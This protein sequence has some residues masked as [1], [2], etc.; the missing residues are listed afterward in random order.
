MKQNNI[1][2]KN[3][4]KFSWNEYFPQEK[5]IPT[6]ESFYQCLVFDANNKTLEPKTGNAYFYNCLFQNMKSSASGG[7]I[8]YQK[9]G[10]CILIERCSFLNCSSSSYSGAVRVLGGDAII[11]HT[12]GYQCSSVFNDG[13]CAIGRDSYRKINSVFDSSVICCKTNAKYIL[14]LEVGRIKIGS[15]NASYNIASSHSPLYCGSS[16]TD[17]DTGIATSVDHCFFF[18]NSAA[19]YCLF[20]YNEYFKKCSHEMKFCN[21]LNN[22]GSSTIWCRNATTITKCCI[23]QNGNP[24]FCAHDQYSSILLIGCQVDN[25][26]CTGLQ[27]VSVIDKTEYVNLTFVQNRKVFNLLSCTKKSWS[28]LPFGKILFYSLIIL[29]LY[30]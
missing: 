12:Y 27:T 14:Y 17:E 19:N 25:T 1:F 13:F 28:I 23:L 9:I 29:F 16:V 24:C 20:L 5:D 8:L 26:N 22:N 4:K 6:D 2:F 11:A 30:L 15:V 21:V 10:S 3:T 18:N 7:A